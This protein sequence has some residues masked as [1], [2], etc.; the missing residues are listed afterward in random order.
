MNSINLYYEGD[1][2]NYGLERLSI[3]L[4]RSR[5]EKGKSNK[6]SSKDAIPEIEI[7]EKI[8]MF[9]RHDFHFKWSI[10]VFL[11]NLYNCFTVPFF[12]GISSFPSGL[13]LSLELFFEFVLVLDMIGRIVFYQS[14]KSKAYW[15]L[16]ES[17]SLLKYLF[18]AFSS[19]PYSFL[20]LIFVSDLSG[21]L[22]AILRGFKLLRHFQ[23]ST[24]FMNLE[25]IRDKN[26][27]YRFEFVKLILILVLCVHYLG[28]F[29][30]FVARVEIETGSQHWNSILISNNA[31]NWEIYSDGLF[32]S[33]ESLTG[34]IVE[35]AYEYSSSE[36]LVSV[37]VM[38]V[39]AFTY[40]II[41]GRIITILERNNKAIEKNRQQL[42]MS[43]IWSK[44]RN[45]SNKLTKRLVVY[46]KIVSEKFL[47]QLDYSFIDEMP[48]SLRT[49]ISIFMYQDLIHKVKIFDLGD[50][51]FMMAMIRHLKPRLYMQG[52]YIIRQ[53]DYASEFYI[54]R[55]GVVEVLASDNVTQISLLDEGSYFGEIGLLFNV[56][57][58]VSV[59]A[60]KACIICYIA[61]ENFL[62]I[63]KSFPEHQNFLKAVAEQ[64]RK[65]VDVEDFE[66]NFDLTEDFSSSDS[67]DNSDDLEPPKFFTEKEHHKKNCIQKMFTVNRSNA[68]SD[69]IIID[70]LS[71]FYYVWTT[72]LAASLGFNFAY[73]P[74]CICFE[75]DGGTWL[76][77]LNFFTYFI[78]LADVWVNLWTAI[79]TEFGTYS[80]SRKEIIKEY[81]NSC[82]VMDV[83]A[84]IP[85][86]FI[87]Y[88][89]G[90]PQYAAAYSRILR[91][92]KF[93]RVS[94][95]IQIILKNSRIHY[96][97][98]RLILILIVLLFS[99]HLYAC[100]F[101][102]VSKF[103]HYYLKDSRY[104]S[105]T[106]I[107]TYNQDFNLTSLLDTTIS[108]QYIT[109]IYFGTSISTAAAYG[110]LYPVA[111]LEKLFCLVIILFARLLIA[112]LYAEF[113][114]LNASL[115]VNCIRHI[116][117]VSQIKKWSKLKQIPKSLRSRILN[118]YELL[119][120][121]LNGYND[122]EI[123][124]DLPEALRTDISYFLFKGLTSSGLFPLTD[125]G[126]IL[127]I[128]RRCKVCVFC[129]DETIM[130]EG[131]LGLEMFFI[132]EGKVRVV[133][134]LNVV[135]NRLGTGSFFGEMSI[136]KPVPDVRLASIIAEVDST[137]AMLSLEDYKYVSSVFPEFADKVTKQAAER[138]NMNRSTFSSENVEALRI[139]QKLADNYDL[140]HGDI[141][142]AV[143]DNELPTEHATPNLVKVKYNPPICIKTKKR[144]K[145][146]AYIIVWIWN[147]IF[148]PYKIAFKENF[149]GF[150]LFME[151][152]TILCYTYFIYDNFKNSVI[153]SKSLK[154]FMNYYL[155][156]LHHLLLAFPFLLVGDY[157]DISQQA[158]GIF[159]LIRISNFYL[160]FPVFS[161]LKQ[162]VNWFI[163]LSLLE[164]LAIFFLIN[165]ILGCYFI[166]ISNNIPPEHS[167]IGLLDPDIS[168][169]SLYIYAFYWSNSTLT[170]SSLGDIYSRNYHERL[171]NSFA[172]I[173]TCI[174]YAFLF[175]TISSLWSG[176]ASQLKSNLQ[177]SYLYVKDFLKKKKVESIFS[178]LIE[179]YYNFIWHDS[180]G[181]TED[182]I[183]KELPHSIKSAIQIFRYSKAITA[184]QVFKDSNSVINQNIVLSIFRIATIQSYLVGDTIIKVGDKSQDMFI[185]LEGEVDVLNIQGK[186]V[187]ATL[188]EGA[189][190]GEANIILKNEM[191]TATIIATK[192]S[193][194]GILT[195]KNLEILF[196]AYPAWYEML[197]NIVKS[198][199]KQTFNTSDRDGVSKQV[200]TISQKLQTIPNSYKKYIKRSEKLMSSKIAE[201]LAKT[202]LG[203]WMT[204]NFVHLIFIIYSS[205]SIPILINF[206]IHSVPTLIAMESL[207]LG[208]SL[209]YFALNLKNSIKKANSKEF[210]M[211]KT[212]LL[213]YKNYVFEDFFSCSPFNLIFSI[214]YTDKPWLYIPLRL[215]RL[216]SVIRINSLLEKMEM[217]DRNLL[218]YIKLCRILLVGIL[219]V[220]WSTC[221]WIFIATRGLW[222][223]NSGLEG[224]SVLKLYEMSL[225]Y[226]MNIVSGSGH[227]NTRPYSDCERVYTVFLSIIGFAVFASSF[228]L[229]ASL[230]SEFSSK[231]KEMVNNIRSPYNI[232]NRTDL[233]EDVLVRLQ[234]YCA[235]TTGLSQTIGPIN[236][237]SLYLHLPPNIVGTII[238]ECNRSLLKKLPFLGNFESAELAEKISLCLIP[239]IYL[240]NDYI[241]YKNDVGEEMFFIILGSVNV[242][243]SDNYKILKTLKKG[244]FFGEVALLTSSRRMCSVRSV[245][246]SLIYALNKSDFLSLLD[247]FP[248]LEAVLAQEAKKRNLEN[249]TI[250]EKKK[251]VGKNEIQEEFVHTLNMYSAMSNPYLTRR[252]TKKFTVLAGMKNYDSQVVKE[253]YGEDHQQKIDKRRPLV[254][255]KERRMSEEYLSKEILISKFSK[256][257]TGRNSI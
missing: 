74:F 109:M 103:Q 135:L 30:I 133:T 214:I 47:V 223:K 112:I 46:Y 183:L 6:Q 221:L 80:H 245:D 70:P 8:R 71:P 256:Y 186:K 138:E 69:R 229:M 35:Q 204:L 179:D 111:I 19:V 208:E 20:S 38:V 76:L 237:K 55:V 36:L 171:F 152:L 255:G 139:Y 235:F 16:Y 44:Q 137:L 65:C 219:V 175:G 144:I 127:S 123:L 31:Q 200:S 180:Q 216:A 29:W 121:K 37:F 233:P 84:L 126:A 154:S 155:P 132:I 176:F 197:E 83:A 173:L 141:N 110:D 33:A 163:I 190:F 42:E 15:L 177:E 222:V 7:L 252:N 166:F 170:H 59:R 246:L 165:H 196:E 48:L 78:Y 52:D 253:S 14:L 174:A 114:T 217:H 247:D 129:A 26:S 199:M 113:S 50:P 158:I 151:S 91:I 153:E 81:I 27:F 68:P 251:F 1:S 56:Y 238:Y 147:I 160:I 157:I 87:C 220:H 241:I 150:S 207:V 226:V 62:Q 39:G 145:S 82:L 131:E 146:S 116:N 43:L 88:F 187:L 102:Y 24:F 53:G 239:Q 210:Q 97:V 164:I 107:S 169:F 232:D 100:L 9:N 2:K 49:E 203:K 240:P 105:S 89:F 178:G 28:C 167:W 189:H 12:L 101:F 143:N 228:G 85:S 34:I 115:N 198:R 61:K 243:A 94:S 172:Y 108:H 124:Q 227:N 148:T 3:D 41:F 168:Q 254:N 5:Q 75:D 120:N 234:Q 73:V 122:E 51:S 149:E 185:I 93:R 209:A 130:T 244:E 86:D 25:I 159:S 142:E 4:H 242:L 64:R 248:E 54:V 136:I 11:T 156:I 225:Y 213:F 45:L 90:A 118:Y 10:L 63:V 60:L 92:F 13:W 211:K 32:W 99:S 193:K 21:L 128:V 215:L 18:L 162:N 67:S 161:R 231:M 125:S 201:I 230:S 98:I 192:I 236:F 58:T 212:L 57:R 95:C 134:S 119:W 257:A 249:M 191:R 194:I 188:R 72:I 96:S 205:I 182:K 79:I 40:A 106:F 184:S 66:K 23:L 22:P 195:K 181:L 224:E 206:Q 250:A 202:S 218:K 104:D 140:N 17:E 77:I 117:K